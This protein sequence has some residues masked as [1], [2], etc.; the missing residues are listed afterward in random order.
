MYCMGGREGGKGLEI[1]LYIDEGL[2]DVRQ[3]GRLDDT[4]KEIED[5]KLRK[6]RM[7][8]LL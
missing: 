5:G 2:K 3:K 6:A 1:T 4:G 7:V 8:V